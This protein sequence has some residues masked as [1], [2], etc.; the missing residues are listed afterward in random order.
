MG[1][2]LVVLAAAGCAPEDADDDA[3]TTPS[4]S[5]AG[6]ACTAASLDTVEAGTLTVATGKPAYQPWFV[7]DDPAN[8]QGFE[9]AVAYAV[10]EEL[11]YPKDKVVWTSA[12]FTASI[13]PGPKPYDVNLQQFSI[14][15]ERKQ[16]VDFS[17]GY[18]DVAQAF[19]TVGT[20]PA[21]NAKSVADLAKLK[22]GAATGT[23]SYEAIV[24]VVK[25]AQQPAVFNDNDQAKLA[26]ANGQID[27]LAVDLPTA[28]YLSAAELDG[29]KVV[30]QLPVSGTTPEQFGFLLEKGS[31]LT[32]CV[33]RAVDALRDAGT[34]DEL[35]KQWL[36]ETAGAPVLS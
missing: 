32:S 1:V 31:P 12:D 34:L 6:A 26:L 10:A 16:A 21:A 9:S 24:D 20:S 36:T 13:A 14:T 22:L 23:T 35:E 17:T 30:G 2:V 19:V 25:P 5:G 8:G 28:L 29:G 33:S 3:A 4:A 15:E 18:Y 7:D 11:G 27:A